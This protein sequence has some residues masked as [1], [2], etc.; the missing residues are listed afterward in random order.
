MVRLPY[1]RACTRTDQLIV[2]QNGVVAEQGEADRVFES[3]S[4][5]YTRALISAA[6]DFELEDESVLEQ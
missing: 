2:L 5:P 3:P 4:G 6:F 1:P